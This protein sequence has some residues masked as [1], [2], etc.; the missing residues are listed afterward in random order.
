ML[1][2]AARSKK[3]ETIVEGQQLRTDIMERACPRLRFAFVRNKAKKSDADMYMHTDIYISAFVHLDFLYRCSFEQF[4][5]IWIF[6]KISHF[7][8][9]FNFL[10]QSFDEFVSFLTFF[11]FSFFSFLNVFTLFLLFDNFL[12]LFAMCSNV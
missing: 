7:L 10:F 9:I 5:N 8:T 12:T 4:Y 1:E 3:H 6:Q 2:T 11:I